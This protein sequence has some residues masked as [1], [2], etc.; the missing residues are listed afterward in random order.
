V[1]FD[2]ATEAAEAVLAVS[3]R[4]RMLDKIGERTKTTAAANQA[5]RLQ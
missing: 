2:D 5:Q 1:S 3:L 4:M